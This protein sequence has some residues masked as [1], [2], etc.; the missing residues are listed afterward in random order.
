MKKLFALILAMAMAF[1][2]V[3][4]GG[5]SDSGTD[6]DGD[7]SSASSAS[8]SEA[9]DE[10]GTE[11]EGEAEASSTDDTSSDGELI[12]VGFAQVG[13]ESDWRT[14]STE[15]CQSVFTE[16]NGYELVFVDC[17]QDSAAQL[18]AV[19]SFI[20]QEVDYIIIDPI[21]STGWDTVLTEC[22]EAGIPVIVIDR[23]IDDSDKYAAWVGSDFTTEGLAAGEW[24]KAYAD[25][26]GIEELNILVI[27]GT[28]GASATIGRTE[29]FQ[30]IAD[31]YGW[32]IL[33]SQDGDFTEA[34][35]QEIMESYCKSYEGQFNVVICQNDNEAFGAMTAMTNA[36]V[37]YGV[38]GDVILISFDACTA[39]LQYVQSGD[40]NAD[41]ECNPLA[42]PFVDEVI[43]QL[44]AGE[45]PETTVYMEEHWYT[46]DDTVSTFEVDGVEQSV[47][48]VTD[49]IIDAQY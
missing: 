27:E 4:C 23:T 29:G 14:A 12:V 40:I 24:L 7:A 36:G 35:G 2:L 22:E 39:G 21:V 47:T 17:D 31:K 10:S 1:S 28:T 30:E 18:E 15:S 43:K 20:Q 49:E 44:E 16:E 41:F 13:H 26:K 45:T 11:D 25:A 48:V 42:A 9:E 32:T 5:S 6:D 3:A 46:Y 38:D 8:T 19:R 37:T 34:G 33:D